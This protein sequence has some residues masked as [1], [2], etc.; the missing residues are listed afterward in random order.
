MPVLGDHPPGELGARARAV[1]A[2]DRHDRR[3]RQGEAGVVGLDRRV[4]PVVMTPVKILAT[5]SPDSR[6]FVT[7]WPLIFRLYMNDVPPA[8]TGMYA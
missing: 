1:G 6:R 7:R 3:G 4:V 8:V 2:H 5:F